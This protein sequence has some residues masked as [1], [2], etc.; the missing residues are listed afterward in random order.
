MNDKLKKKISL[1]P[2][3]PGIYK[4]KDKQGKIIYVGK[5]V[6]LQSRV[7]SYFRKDLELGP[8]TVKLVENIED[9]E[10]LETESEVDALLLE[11]ELIKR[12]KPKYNVLLRDDKFYKYIEIKNEKVSYIENGISRLEIISRVITSRKVTTPGSNYF[13][14]YPSGTYVDDVLRQFRKTFKYRDCSK[15]KYNLYQ[16][17][18]KPCLFGDIGLCLAPC[19][20]NVTPTEY[21]RSIGQFK[22]LLSGK[23]SSVMT[24]LKTQ[25]QKASKNEQYESAT[26]FRDR[27]EKLHY[28]RQNNRNANDYIENPNLIEDI[29]YQALLNLK[30]LIPTLKQLPQ[31]IECFDI[32]N[33]QGTNPTASMVVAMDGRLDKSEYR[34]FKI[35]S[36]STPDD[37]LMMQEAVKRRFNNNWPMPNLLVIDGGKG[38]LRAVIKILDLLGL[39]LPIIGLAKKEETIV[40]YDKESFELITLKKTQ[41]ELRLLQRLRDEAHRFAIIYHRKLR[42]RSIKSDKGI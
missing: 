42:S 31:R 23:S 34:K 3:T 22:K 2:K 1:F 8:K 18:H 33:T 4:Y 12:L 14:P 19:V 7:K 32:S 25:M 15:V 28:L 16:K 13:G 38:Q 20:G 9:M 30:N 5:A 29:N 35:M 37:F 39:K 11:A 36:K 40:I 26:V 10:I 21:R 17:K 41:P 6:N 24:E 27:L